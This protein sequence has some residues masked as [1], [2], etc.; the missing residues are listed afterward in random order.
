[1][2]LTG[3]ALVLAALVAV[4]TGDTLMNL[5]DQQAFALTTIDSVPSSQ[6]LAD[7]TLTVPDDLVAVAANLNDNYDT[8]VR[9]RAIRGLAVYCKS[10]GN[11]CPD[12]GSVHQALR[13]LISSNKDAHAGS[14]LLLLRAAIESDGPLKVSGDLDLLLPLLDHPSRDIRATTAR[15]LGDLCNTASTTVDRLRQRYQNESTDQVKLAISA[16]LRILSQPT[17]CLVN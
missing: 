12:T 13:T 16:T 3:I 9:L 11:S 7:A 10:P 14:D 2:K 6:Q 5:S 8:A 1:M 15:A 17:N 4:A